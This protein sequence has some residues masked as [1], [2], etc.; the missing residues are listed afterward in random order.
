MHN[1][2]HPDIVISTAGHD[3]GRP[4]IVLKRDGAFLLLVDGKTRKLTNPKGKSLKHVKKA[5]M[6]TPELAGAFNS[7]TATDSLIRKELAKFRSEAGM[8][9]EGSQLVKRRFN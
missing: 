7:G 8:T 6:G 9:E 1:I 5:K 4:Y 2:K 3:K